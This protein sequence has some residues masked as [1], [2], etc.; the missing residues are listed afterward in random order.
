VNSGTRHLLI[1][2]Y[3]PTYEFY[4]RL[5]LDQMGWIMYCAYHMNS[6]IEI[7]N[8]TT[9]SGSPYDILNNSYGFVCK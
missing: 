1:T 9:S 7:G 6:I 8:L 2:I 5:V 4:H 3:V